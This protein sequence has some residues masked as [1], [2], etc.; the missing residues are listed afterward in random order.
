MRQAHAVDKAAGVSEAMFIRSALIFSCALALPLL[1]STEHANAQW[2]GGMGGGMGGGGPGSRGDR[3]GRPN[4]GN[5]E[6]RIEKP[7]IDP[8][9]Y[10]QIDYRLSMLEDDLKLT[11]MQQRAWQAFAESVKTYANDLSRER[12]R[13]QPHTGE[14]LSAPSGL[15]HVSQAV[16]SARNRM[17]ALELIETSAKS[18]YQDL[19]PD[20]KML[21]DSRIPTFVAPRLRGPGRGPEPGNRPEFS[22]ASELPTQR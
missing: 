7:N 14:I 9:S 3:P 15:Q 5:R 8:E 22:P 4:M 13:N 21:A 19:T 18:L 10:E 11:S 20:Q 17:T 16:D 6:N 2:G 12:T 1:L